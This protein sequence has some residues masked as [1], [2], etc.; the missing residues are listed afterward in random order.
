M[1]VT[2]PGRE[3]EHVGLVLALRENNGYHDSYFSATY[4]NPETGG[5]ESVTYDSTA[6]AGGGKAEVDAPPALQ[7]YWADVK[8]ELHERFARED[9]EAAAKVP[10]KG[11]VVKVTKSFKPRGQERVQVGTEA[12]VFWFG[13]S[14]GERRV[15]LELVESGRK[16]FTKASNVE[17]LQGLVTA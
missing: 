1:A 8:R 17:V 7:E 6:Y 5:F 15:G 9:A 13:E 16:V 4:F 14:Y 11:K 10:T 3:P 2:F 12:E